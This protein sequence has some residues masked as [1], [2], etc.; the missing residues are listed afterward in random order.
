MMPSN[1][2]PPDYITAHNM[3][4]V[5]GNIHS[6][7]ELLRKIAEMLD[8]TEGRDAAAFLSDLD[9]ATDNLMALANAIC[10][11]HECRPCNINPRETVGG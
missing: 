8:G 2:L 6:D 10:K 5:L 9:N 4:V 1:P 7:R 11:S 3:R